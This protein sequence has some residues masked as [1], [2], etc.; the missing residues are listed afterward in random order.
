[1]TPHLFKA[2]APFKSHMQKRFW[3]TSKNEHLRYVKF[4]GDK[5]NR[6][7]VPFLGQLYQYSTYTGF[8][9]DTI[10]RKKFGKVCATNKG[11]AVRHCFSSSKDFIASLVRLNMRLVVIK[12]VNGEELQNPIK[13]LNLFKLI[14]S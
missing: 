11:A 8:T 9:R 12:S 7:L 13:L 10:Y 3:G 6:T 14:G 2:D 5:C 1:M 4:L